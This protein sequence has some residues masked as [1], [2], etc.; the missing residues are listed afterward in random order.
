M[1]CKTSR[2]APAALILTSFPGSMYGANEVT[3]L[4]TGFLYW[5]DCTCRYEN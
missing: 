1:F 5:N 3:A 4:A 2:F